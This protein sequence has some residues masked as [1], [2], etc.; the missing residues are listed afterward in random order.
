MLTDEESR[1][2]FRNGLPCNC[3]Q[4]NGNVPFFQFIY[5]SRFAIFKGECFNFMGE[6]P[7]INIYLSS[8]MSLTVKLCSL[9]EG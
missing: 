4:E 1:K 5:A 6:I 8:L 9:V 7:P 2:S 3:N